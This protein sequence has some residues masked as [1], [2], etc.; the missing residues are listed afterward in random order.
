MAIVD[1]SWVAFCR[2]EPEANSQCIA[3]IDSGG[4]RGQVLA[5]SPVAREL[6]VKRGMRSARVMALS[7]KLRLRVE[8]P[9]AREAVREALRDACLAF[10]PAVQLVEERDCVLLNA[11]GVSAQWGSEESF[12]SAIEHACRKVGL[13]VQTSIASATLSAMALSQLSEGVIVK[14]VAEERSALSPLPLHVLSLHTSAESTLKS[15]GIRTLGELASLNAQDIATRVSIEAA[16]AVRVACGEDRTIV[17]PQLVED[18]FEER[19]NF[20]WELFEIE[21]L[22][23]ATKPLFTAVIAR[24]SC[25]GFSARSGWVTFSLLNKTTHRREVTVASATREVSVWMR[26]L[27]TSLE[28]APPKHA[29]I[30]ASVELFACAPRAVQLGLFDRPGPSPEKW[31]LAL[32][33]IEAKVGSARVGMAGPSL[34]HRPREVRM[35]PWEDE[36]KIASTEDLLK[37]SEASI[38]TPCTV[39]TALTLHVFRPPRPVR[40]RFEHGAISALLAEAYTERTASKMPVKMHDKISGRVLHCAGPYRVSGSWWDNPFA[41]DTYDVVLEDSVMYRVGYDGKSG[42]WTLEGRY[43]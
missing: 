24:L 11:T 38:D 30:G 7:E 15:M 9:A 20:D 19:A 4:A 14:T 23:F 21:P 35:L 18:R 2:R 12:V 28:A 34:T 33:R 40:V 31:S 8:D 32:A 5:C 3:V 1:P 17:V 25:R 27:H 39:N 6:G 22:L 16:Q 36:R 37:D 43:E 26:L 42:L 13:T 41:Q 10:V 29:V